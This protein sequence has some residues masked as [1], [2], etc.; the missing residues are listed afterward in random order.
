MT[1]LSKSVYTAQTWDKLG[2]RNQ[3]KETDIPRH[4]HVANEVNRR[5]SFLDVKA[6]GS[7][8]SPPPLSCLG[9]LE[10]EIRT[11]DSKLKEAALKNQRLSRYGSQRLMSPNLV[12]VRPCLENTNRLSR[13]EWQVHF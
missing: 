4:W 3:L 11:L 1:N 10:G 5:P 12:L 7:V 9:E 8:T 6:S 13:E 2:S